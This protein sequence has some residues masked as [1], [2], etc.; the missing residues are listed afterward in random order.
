MTPI[1]LLTCRHWWYAH[2]F[3]LPDLMDAL[4][5]GALIGL[6]ACTCYITWAIGMVE[7]GQH[8]SQERA[9][10]FEMCSKGGTLGYVDDGH[11]QWSVRCSIWEER[12]R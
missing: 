4:L 5:A 3:E 9:K 11:Q 2:R 7:Q 1:R 10:M 12:V 8:D 6:I